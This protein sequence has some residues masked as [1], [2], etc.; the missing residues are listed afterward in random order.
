MQGQG[1]GGRADGGIIEIFE[2]QEKMFGLSVFLWLMR[3][4]ERA[5]DEESE[6]IS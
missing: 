1:C 2:H 6:I 3:S 5:F 4:Q